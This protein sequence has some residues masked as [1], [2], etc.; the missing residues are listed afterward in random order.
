MRKEILFAIIA[1]GLFGAIIA[2]GVW[3]ANV[4]LAPGKAS[5]TVSEPETKPKADGELAISLAKPEELDVVSVSPTTV[6]GVTSPNTWVVL[7]TDETDYIIKSNNIGSFEQKI[8]L[9]GGVNQISITAFR[10]TANSVEKNLTLI[11]STEFPKKTTNSEDAPGDQEATNSVRKKVQQKLEAAISKPK[12]YLGTVTDITENTIQIKSTKDEIQQVS[13][14]A[15]ETDFIKTGKTK[16]AVKYS[17]VAIGDF[18]IAMGFINEDGVL[19]AKRVL[20]TQPAEPVRRK[21]IYVEIVAIDGKTVTLKV[22]DEGQWTAK[23]GKKWVGPELN[24]LS[25]GLK[26]IVAGVTENTTVSVRT[27]LIIPEATSSPSPTPSP[28]A[29]PSPPPAGGSTTTPSP[30]AVGE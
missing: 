13:V 10:D 17:D 24:E 20:L 8:E 3:R 5:V 1:G 14:V 15:E 11:Y 26:V 12:A 28:S 9:I 18:V 27:L 16:Q 21:A 4:A 7:S 29:S 25:E 2:F 22:G 19:D 30:E 6:S 23:F